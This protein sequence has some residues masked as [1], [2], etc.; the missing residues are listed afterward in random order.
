MPHLDT[1]D[2]KEQATANA[3]IQR[4]DKDHFQRLLL[5]WVA[6]SFR[7]PEHFRLRRIFEYLNPSVAAKNARISRNTVR[8]RI[9]DLNVKV[10]GQIHIAFDG[11]RP[12]N[13]HALYEIVCFYVD[14]NGAPSKLVPG[15][16]ELKGSHSGEIIAAQILESLESYEIIDKVG[17]MT[18]DNAGNM[19][20]ATQETAMAMGVDLKQRRVRYFGHVLNMV[21][22]ALLFGQNPA[23]FKA[24]VDEEPGFDAVQHAIWRKRGPVGKL[25]NLIHWIHR[26]DKLT[27]RLRALQGDFFQHSDSPRIRARKPLDVIR[28]NQT[29]WLEC[30]NGV[31]RK[32]E[33][34]LCVREESLLSENDWKVVELMDEVLVDFEEAIRML[35]GDAQRRTRKGG[36]IEVYGNMWDVALTDEFLMQRLETWKATAENYPDPE[37]FKVSINLGRCKLNDYYT[38]LDE[39]PAYYASAILNPFLRWAYFENTWTDRA[40]LVWLQEAKRTV[41]KLWEEEYKSLPRL[42][43]PDGEPQ[44]KRLKVMSALE[45]HRACRTSSL[46]GENS[47]LTCPW[48]ADYDEY[49]HWLLNSDAKHDPLVTDPVRYWWERRND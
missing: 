32:E 24:E 4:F 36:R 21:T 43:L 47:C 22:K 7:Q 18:L 42:S 23:A 41:R 2:A 37:Y 44:L 3:L 33:V 20:T 15:L 46:P 31:R 17:Y 38:K 6:V 10:P 12:R 29:R 45:R 40:Q 48:D 35:E 8:K 11:W 14:D 9:A 16:P 26:S 49:D 27:H 25:H 39:T 19:D 1:S 30:R 5:E 28:D 13:R 34:P